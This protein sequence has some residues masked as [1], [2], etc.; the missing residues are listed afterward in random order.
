MLSI[1]PRTRDSPAGI[2]SLCSVG[3]RRAGGAAHMHIMQ[4]LCW[5]FW[6]SG[7]LI[8]IFIMFVV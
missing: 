2:L 5:H 7:F 8:E 4:A 1:L 3:Q 6:R